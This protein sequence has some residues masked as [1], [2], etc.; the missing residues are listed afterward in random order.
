MV[1]RID[2]DYGFG[3]RFCDI[4]GDIVCQ[5]TCGAVL[6]VAVCFPYQQKSGI[7]R[8]HTMIFLLLLGISV[9]QLSRLHMCVFC[10]WC[11]KAFPTGPIIWQWTSTVFWITVVDLMFYHQRVQLSLLEWIGYICPYKMVRKKFVLFGLGP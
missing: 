4:L 9:S 7:V 8:Y 5:T 1:L 10:K 3:F 2:A 11:R 6:D